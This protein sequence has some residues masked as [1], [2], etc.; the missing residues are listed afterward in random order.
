MGV[1]YHKQPIVT[2]GLVYEIDA[3]NKLSYSGAGVTAYELV[4]RNNATLINGITFS[5]DAWIQDG[6]DDY[7][8]MGQPDVLDIDAFTFTSWFKPTEN[9]TGIFTRGSSRGNE[10]TRDLDIFGNGTNLI[11]LG[12]SSVPASLITGTAGHHV[13]TTFPTLNEWHEV[14]VTWD[15][16]TNANTFIA[17]LNGVAFGSA[18]AVTTTIAKRFNYH[19]GGE[20]SFVG[21]SSLGVQRG[22][23]K[24]LTQS[25]VTQNYE[26]Q[27]SRYIN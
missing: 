27:K 21:K 12:I 13:Q 19:F 17:Y 23:N 22:Y 24:A 5:D 1:H 8:D 11:V 16:T 20:G 25:E 3:G 4:N 14:T 2:D 18:T 26:S 7:V 10:T 9:N 15:G 6:V